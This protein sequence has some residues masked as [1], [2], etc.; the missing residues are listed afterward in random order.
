MLIQIFEEI[1]GE[2]G[3]K[4]EVT[5]KDIEKQKAEVEISAEAPADESGNIKFQDSTEDNVTAAD[6]Q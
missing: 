2:E 5:Q 4:A 3:G 1:Q 6:Q